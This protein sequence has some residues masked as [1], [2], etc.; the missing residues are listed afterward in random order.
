MTAKILVVDDVPV[1]VKLLEVRLAAEHF[2]VIPVFDSREVLRVCA[3]TH[4]DVVLLDVMMPGMDG[5]TLCRY[6]KTDPATQHIPVIMVTAL[7]GASD[8]LESVKAGA[9]DFLTKPVN[10]IALVTRVRNLVRLKKLND[11]VR[12][13]VPLNKMP[14]LDGKEGMEPVVWGEQGRVLVVEHNLSRAERLVQLLAPRYLVEVETNAGRV[15]QRLEHN[16]FDVSFV[17]LNRKATDGLKLC[18]EICSAVFLPSL[19]LVMLAEPGDEAHVAHG[20][21]MGADDYIMRPFERH[22]LLARTHVQIKQKRYTDFLSSYGI[23]A[24]ENLSDLHG[25]AS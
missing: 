8:K 23:E 7:N 6:L 16:S 12:A 2:D 19:Q 24:I 5:F 20:L 18:R 22:E 4:I 21:D 11:A 14:C 10:D 1:N 13:R 25:R 15:M 17:S 9:D 3:D